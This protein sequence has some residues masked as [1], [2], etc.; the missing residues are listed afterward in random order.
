M[1]N[2][3]ILFLIMGCILLFNSCR[4]GIETE[5]VSIITTA[6]FFKT[7]D[8]VLG[9]LRGMYF[10]LRIPASGDLY[11]MGEGRS[12]I[13][14]SAAAGTLTFDRYYNNTLNV[15]NPGP[16][17]MSLYTV[18]NTAN[19]LLKYTPDITFSSDAAK[20][21][22]LAQAY[23]MRAFIYFS[24]V[25]TWGGVPIRTEPTEK[26]DPQTIQVAR[27]GEDEVFQLIKDDLE[28]ALALYPDNTID[29]TRSYWNKAAANALKGEVYLWT[30][31]LRSGGAADFN[32]ALTALTDAKSSDV[33]L[34]PNYGDIFS[35]TNKT[36]KE[37]LMAVRFQLLDQAPNNYFTN[38]Y[39]INFSNL[40]AAAQTVIGAQGGNGS[41]MQI[42]EPVR[43]L[44]T[45]DDQRRNAT[46]YELYDNSN[47]FISAL[48]MKGRGVVDGGT[49]YFLT[50][51]ILYRL[52][53][54]L[55]LIAEAKN[56]LGQDPSAEINQVRQRAY[57]ADA[58]TH[59]FVNGSKEANDAAILKERLLE[60]CTEGKRWW[61]LIRFNQ[62]FNM[63]P[64]LQ[65]KEGDKYLLLFPV[66]QTIRSL[67]P[68]VT[69]NPG[70]E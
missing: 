9:V 62:V 34:L 54:V 61:D 30:G 35:Y 22:V 38:M 43:N 52:A 56:A 18:V 53:D 59:L 1:N 49:R 4:K 70:W 31:K 6:T 64:S 65:G 33:Q 55:L 25:R 7:Q 57:G 69:E 40:P 37:V 3:K 51:V 50:D 26:Y 42:R 5:P 47:K 29:A 12:D 46:F 10:Q 36:N 23:T 13:L 11:F 32:T 16:N 39:L 28:K 68:L 19:L 21:N 67:E 45:S 2:K 44:F 8:D 20:N 14:T 41:V 24:L 66:G 63:V 17:W 58:A 60:F 48:T 15:T 27:S